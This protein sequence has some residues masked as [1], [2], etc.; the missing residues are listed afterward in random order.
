MEKIKIALPEEDWIQFLI[1]MLQVKK[2]RFCGT[3][4]S[5][6]GYSIMKIALAQ[7]MSQ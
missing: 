7:R 6:L 5:F 3:V 1:E 2:T 4:S